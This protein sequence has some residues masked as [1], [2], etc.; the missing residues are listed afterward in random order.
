MAMSNDLS[1]IKVYI[2]AVQ[3]VMP[4]V[5][6]DP[7]ISRQV[8]DEKSS[9]YS[10]VFRSRFHT[11]LYYKGS[12]EDS[13][14]LLAG[15]AKESLAVALSDQPVFAGRLRRVVKGGDGGLEI[16][17][18]DS[19]VRLIEARISM[20]LE[21][22]LRLRDKGDAESQLVFWE[23]IDEQDPQFSP[24]Y[25]VQASGIYYV[26]YILCFFLDHSTFNNIKVTNLNDLGFRTI[27]RAL[28]IFLFLFK[29][30]K[31]IVLFFQYLS[32]EDHTT[33]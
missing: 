20:N 3:T 7:R 11:I 16:V 33:L 21:E 23:S 13:G 31:I 15:W 26:Y 29:Q 27:R 22:F 25:Y 10:T 28:S 32:N 4:A 12:S 19:G 24:L 9:K 1:S 18:N 30:S 14:W 8:L 6:T 17:P 5:P 2:E